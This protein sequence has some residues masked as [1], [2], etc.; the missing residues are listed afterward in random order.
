MEYT[1]PSGPGQG[2][3]SMSGN[4]LFALTSHKAKVFPQA[5]GRNKVHRVEGAI[6][7]ICWVFSSL[8]VLNGKMLLAFVKL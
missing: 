7:Y 4:I 8:F 1:G 3:I 2:L 6:R 5:F